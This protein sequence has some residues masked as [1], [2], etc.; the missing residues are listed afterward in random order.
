M[1]I[2]EDFEESHPKNIAWLNEAENVGGISDINEVMTDV[3]SPD[4]MWPKWK[5][6]DESEKL[7]WLEAFYETV[8]FRNKDTGAQGVVGTSKEG[9]GLYY[10]AD[11]GSDDIFVDKETFNREYEIIRA[12]DKR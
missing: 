1:S 7:A 8:E 2:K 5:A 4:N 10:G 12:C 6:K 9:I 11:D 3:W